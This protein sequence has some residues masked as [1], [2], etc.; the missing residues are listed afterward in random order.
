MTPLSRASRI[1]SVVLLLLVSAAS[2]AHN[3]S[4]NARLPVAGP[5]PEFSLLDQNG[6]PFTLTGLRGK[7]VVVNFIYTRCNRACPVLTEKMASLQAMLGPDFDSRVHFVSISVDPEIDTPAVLRDYAKTHGANVPGWSFLTGTRPM[8]EE[9][10]RAY[11]ALRKRA[12][13]SGRVE[14]LFVTSL[15]DR[16]GSLRV[17]YLG[18]GFKRE[19]LFQDLQ[20][21]LGE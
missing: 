4:E 3:S 18:V 13:R 8:V 12:T 10:E 21:L 17:R 2:W 15:I 14:H 5:A 7:V 9:V 19:E 6:A 1:M 11:G 16:Q 20:V